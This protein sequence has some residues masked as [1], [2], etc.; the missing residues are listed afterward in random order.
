MS[1]QLHG[2]EEMVNTFF[3]FEYHYLCLISIDVL[4]GI[5]SSYLEL[6]AFSQLNSPQ[7]LEIIQYS[8]NKTFA[9][10]YRS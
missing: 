9:N 2:S 8:K 7:Y 1:C 3:I 6:L 4:Y 5:F 10:V